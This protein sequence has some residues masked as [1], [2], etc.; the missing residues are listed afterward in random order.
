[1]LQTAEKLAVKEV[2]F[3]IDGTSSPSLIHESIVAVSALSLQASL[4]KDGVGKA[5]IP[6][7][8]INRNLIA[9]LVGT[10]ATR[11]KH[12]MLQAIFILPVDRSM[13]SAS[14]PHP[15]P[16]QVAPGP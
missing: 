7:T 4:E 5:K 6:A 14:I 1:M 11:R 3:R 13:H 16:A 15:R 10:S 2:Q 12:R 9:A 8:N